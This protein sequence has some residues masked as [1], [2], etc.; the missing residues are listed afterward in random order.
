[1]KNDNSSRSDAFEF[2]HL[3]VGACHQ[4]DDRCPRHAHHMG[5]DGEGQGQHRQGRRI[6]P[7]GKR[8]GFVNV[9]DRG[10]E[11]VGNSENRHQDIGDKKVWHRY[12]AQRNHRDRAVKKRVTVKR[13][14]YTEN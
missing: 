11:A 8:H 2:G 4:A 13:G 12:P 5:A 1:M 3:D 9:R 6:D 7:L 10:E 14:K